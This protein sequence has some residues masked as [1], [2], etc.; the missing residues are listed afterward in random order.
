M[1]WRVASS[2]DVI[3]GQINARFPN[4]DK[5]ADGS[6]GDA[7]HRAE[8]TGSDHNPDQYG[9]VRARDFDKDTN[10][11]T[12]PN[13][14]L[15]LPN[16]LLAS[17]DER[18][19]YVIANRQIFYGTG[20]CARVQGAPYRDWV[21]LPYYESDP[22]YGHTHLSV[23]PTALA[24]N[25]TQWNLGLTEPTEPEEKPKTPERRDDDMF[26]MT[27]IADGRNAAIPVDKQRTY[28]LGPGIYEDITGEKGSVMSALLPY[29]TGNQRQ[30]DVARSLCLSLAAKVDTAGVARE[31]VSQLGG[32]AGLTA[33]DVEKAVRTVLSQTSL[34]VGE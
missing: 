13:L 16:R 14:N 9:V 11:P 6:I 18:I 21:W 3:L 29:R 17:H 19:K 10:D 30:H 33:D 5:G 20:W 27:V 24:D 7:A 2:L 25:T 1:S 12:I 32:K 28:L 22:H 26:I 34:S 4:R 8:G 31:I 15:W 23:V